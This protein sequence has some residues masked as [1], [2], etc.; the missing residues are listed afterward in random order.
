MS[1]TNTVKA[2]VLPQHVPSARARTADT[3]AA[4]ALKEAVER[5]KYTE[6]RLAEFGLTSRE[7]VKS[8]MD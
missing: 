4:K 2:T 3:W 1:K 5:K 7:P 8:L 6:A